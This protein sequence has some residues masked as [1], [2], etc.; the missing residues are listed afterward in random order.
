M[1]WSDGRS[2]TQGYAG[3]HTKLSDD[4]L[5]S[6]FSGRSLISEKLEIF[7]HVLRQSRQTFVKLGFTTQDLCDNKR[8]LDLI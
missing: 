7:K 1:E 2:Q 5:V 8:I 6:Q 4:E 3:L